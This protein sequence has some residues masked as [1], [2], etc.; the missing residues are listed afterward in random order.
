MN[1]VHSSSDAVARQVRSAKRTSSLATLLLFVL[2]CAH[3]QPQSTVYDVVI[4]GGTIY[5]GLGG[6]PFIGDVGIIG[7]RIRVTGDFAM[8]NAKLEIDARGMAVAPGFINMLSWA[9]ESLIQDGRSQGDIRQG[10]TLEVMGEGSSMGPLT[11]TMRKEMIEQEAD[12]K[13][14]IPWTTLGQYL[15]FLVKKGV[16]PNV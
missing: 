4:R 5:N 2:S 14:D 10:V 15:D 12:I 1:L 3:P 16:S 8:P 6:A 11:D 13:Y 9:N 7:D